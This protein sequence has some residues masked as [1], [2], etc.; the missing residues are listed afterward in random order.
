MNDER[1]PDLAG[2]LGVSDLLY[3]EKQILALLV[4]LFALRVRCIGND[5]R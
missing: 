2:R 4:V 1:W 3:L 5:Y